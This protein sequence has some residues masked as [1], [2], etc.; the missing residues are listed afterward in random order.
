[1]GTYNKLHATIACPRCG[2]ID[3][4]EVELRLGK[5]AQMQDL[6]LGDR[7]PWVPN[8]KP[9]NGGRPEGGNADGDGYMECEHCHKDSFLRVQIREDVIIGMEP[10]L[11]KHGYIPD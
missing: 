8:K 5:T 3:V 4:V 11:E 10:N 1:M 7:Y 6:R 9:Q 2:V